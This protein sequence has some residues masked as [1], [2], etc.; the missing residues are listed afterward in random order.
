MY[1]VLITVVLLQAGRGGG[2]SDM[3]GGGQPQSLFGTQTNQFMTR[4]TEVCA[5]MFIVTSLSL[6]IMST[7]RGK[8]LVERNR[9]SRAMKASLPA[10][11]GQKA[12]LAAATV[13]SSAADEV[14]QATVPAQAVPAAAPAA[15]E[16]AKA[17][18][19]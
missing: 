7:Q 5:V 13:P 3:L 11:P 2:M 19:R 4:A 12:P 18:A 16:P 9:F 14:K 1:I 15:Q 10:M 8:S 6:G 17:D